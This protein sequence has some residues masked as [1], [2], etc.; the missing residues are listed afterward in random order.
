MS[1]KYKTLKKYNKK[2]RELKRDMKEIKKRNNRLRKI[3]L[4]THTCELDYTRKE[5]EY[6]ATLMLLQKLLEA[7]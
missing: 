5:L 2:I 4:C 3:N 7:K 1:D 6:L